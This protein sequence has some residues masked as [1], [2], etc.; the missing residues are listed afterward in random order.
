MVIAMSDEKRMIIYVV[1]AGNYSDYH[2]VSATTDREK[3]EEIAEWYKKQNG[4]RMTM[5]T[6]RNT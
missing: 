4:I 1:T 3:A 5:Y 6:S 2:I